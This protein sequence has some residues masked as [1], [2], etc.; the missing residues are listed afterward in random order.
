M[1]Q[2]DKPKIAAKLKLVKQAVKD[3][4]KQAKDRMVTAKA[5]LVGDRERGGE[6]GR[7]RERRRERRRE[8]HDLE[9]RF[10][11]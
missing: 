11:I 5:A 10:A 7:E 6:R 9:F 4:A 8:R 2:G 3:T 1:V